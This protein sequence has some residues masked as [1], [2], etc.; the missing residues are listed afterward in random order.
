M[1]KD[2]EQQPLSTH[3]E[4]KHSKLPPAIDNELDSAAEDQKLLRRIDLW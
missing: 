1:R 4:D 3:H 2:L